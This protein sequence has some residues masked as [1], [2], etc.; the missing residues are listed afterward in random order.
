MGFSKRKKKELTLLRSSKHAIQ[1]DG[2]CYQ[3]ISLL[4]VRIPK[5]WYLYHGRSIGRENVAPLGTLGREFYRFS[6]DPENTTGVHLWSLQVY[7]L[8][9]R[10]DSLPFE[11]N[12]C[13][14][15]GGLTY[16]PVSN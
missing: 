7:K 12:S 11:L 5:G 8:E 9:E 14:K 13:L 1:A 6:H 10:N 3:R 2:Q 15:N 4:V 16:S